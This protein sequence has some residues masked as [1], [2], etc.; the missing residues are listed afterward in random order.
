MK[1]Q[2]RNILRIS[3]LLCCLWCQSCQSWGEET[4]LLETKEFAK[5]SMS[6]R[7]IP[8]WFWNNT[9]VSVSP[10]VQQLG[11]MV[12][13]DGYGGC[14]ILPFG[15]GFR[16]D[17]LSEGYFHLYGEAVSKARALGAHMSIYDEY[18]F[19]SG[20]MGA[21]NGSGVTTFMNNHPEHTIKR[22]DKTEYRV[23]SGA[24]FNRQIALQGK[25]HVG[26]GLEHKHQGDCSA[27]RQLRRGDRSGDVDCPK[28]IR[29]ARDGVPVRQ[30][31]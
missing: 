6:W 12:E 26:C 10:L 4:P 31:R 29:L 30:G 9:Q 1:H 11:Q 24:T 7:P 22:L 27:P 8:L 13:T 2:G 25:A 21:I 28:A 14:A 3:V 16:P 17:Y 20:S 19:P 23:G 18:G 15:T 5:P